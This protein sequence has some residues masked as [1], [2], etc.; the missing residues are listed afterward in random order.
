MTIFAYGKPPNS[1]FEVEVLHARDCQRLPPFLGHKTQ[2]P[3]SPSH[4]STSHVSTRTE[5]RILSSRDPVPLPRSGRRQ[6]Q[7]VGDRGTDSKGTRGRGTLFRGRVVSPRPSPLPHHL[8]SSPPL[9]TPD[10]L[11]CVWR[12][13]HVTEKLICETVSWQWG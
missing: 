12:V 1:R 6:R 7:W 9:P 10:T 4:R 5:P 8:S 2:V 3:Q 11:N 13:R